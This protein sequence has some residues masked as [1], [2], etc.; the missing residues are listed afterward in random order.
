[1][2]QQNYSQLSVLNKKTK[3]FIFQTFQFKIL[4][5]SNSDYTTQ[6]FLALKLNHTQKSAYGANYSRMDQV[7]FVEGSL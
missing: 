2:R 1:M 3:A 5:Y 7:K 6:L 4:L